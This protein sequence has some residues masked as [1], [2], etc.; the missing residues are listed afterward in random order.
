VGQNQ[1]ENEKKFPEISILSHINVTVNY[2]IN[3]QLK[4]ISTE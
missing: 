3:F 4:V 1:V 2:I